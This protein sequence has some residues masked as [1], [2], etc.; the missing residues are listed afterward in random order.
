MDKKSLSII[1][2][3]AILTFGFIVMSFV[4]KQGMDN[5]TFNGRTISVRGVATRIV[6]ADYAT[7]YFNLNCEGSTPLEA[8][9]AVKVYCDSIVSFARTC[10]I[11]SSSINVEPAEV[12]IQ[13]VWNDERIIST[14]Y[15]ASTRVDFY[16]EGEDVLKLNDLD[17]RH[18][19]LIDMG[20][21]V[22]YSNFTYSFSDDALTKI[23]PEMITT[24]TENAR[25]AAEQLAKDNNCHVGD[26]VS[27]QQ[28]YFE[29][30]SIEGRPDYEKQVRVVN[31]AEFYLE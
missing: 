27:A 3:S 17:L 25:I 19:Y 13:H 10:G 6:Q 21:M 11:P 2:A 1:I 5:R 30:G 18:D 16:V 14:Y 31:N 20:V 26:I 12:E 29:V 4:V 8:K 15:T 22:S 7:G 9:N 23:K 24:A 28:G